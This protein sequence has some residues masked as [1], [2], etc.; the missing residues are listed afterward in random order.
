LTPVDPVQ[1]MQ[2]ARETEVLPG[3]GAA[4]RG[5]RWRVLLTHVG[6]GREALDVYDAG[7]NAGYA[8]QIRVLPAG[9]GKL[10]KGERWDYEVLLAQLASE[11]EAVV[12]AKKI[13]LQLGFEAVPAK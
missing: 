7:S 5:G 9:A 12:V 1:F 2:W 3:D 6:S 13:K 10:E 11:Q 8:A 4:Q